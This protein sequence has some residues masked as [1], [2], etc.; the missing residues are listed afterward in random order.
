MKSILLLCCMI[1]FNCMAAVQINSTQYWQTKVKDYPELSEPKVILGWHYFLKSKREGELNYLTKS[2]KQLTDSLE[3]H[4]SRNGIKLGL[5]LANYQHDFSSVEALSSFYLSRWQY[6]T[7]VMLWR[8]QAAIAV[9]NMVLMQEIEV[10]LAS[11]SVDEYTLI[12]KAELF[13]FNKQYE[14]QIAALKQALAFISN[15]QHDPQFKAWLWLQIAAIQIDKLE[16]MT[17]AND[18][19]IQAEQLNPIDPDIIRHRIEWLILTGDLKLA[20]TKLTHLRK[21]HNHREL[22]SF[23]IAIDGKKLARTHHKSTPSNLCLLTHL[24]NK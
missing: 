21:W 22:D 16:D 5:V 15:K 11:F 8:L 23:E 20:K 3:L 7:Q 1:G 6:D 12:G 4:M 24:F 18:A 10:E 17:L 9:N 13:G 19:L 14:L 2:C